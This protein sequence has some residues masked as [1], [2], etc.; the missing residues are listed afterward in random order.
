MYQQYVLRTWDR[1]WVKHAMLFGILWF[2][3]GYDLIAYAMLVFESLSSMWVY[4]RTQNI[5]ACSS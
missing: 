4:K 5:F 1:Y 3:P 2:A